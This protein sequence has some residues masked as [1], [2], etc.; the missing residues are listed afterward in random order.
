MPSNEK[1]AVPMPTA[2]ETATYIQLFNSWTDIPAMAKEANFIHRQLDA[3]WEAIPSNI[4]LGMGHRLLFLTL[5]IAAI[6]AQDQ[7]ML[8]LKGAAFARSLRTGSASGNIARMLAA[9]CDNDARMV[10][11][12]SAASVRH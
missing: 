9:A 1:H 8:G 6:P 10:L 5:A 2:Q 11:A 4:R 3:H 7:E 12:K